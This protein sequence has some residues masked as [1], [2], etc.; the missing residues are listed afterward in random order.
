MKIALAV[1]IRRSRWS[2]AFSSKQDGDAAEFY[3]GREKED[4]SSPVAP[5]LARRT[6]DISSLSSEE[7]LDEGGQK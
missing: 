1:D 5:R 6:R 2:E 7:V 3:V 4:I